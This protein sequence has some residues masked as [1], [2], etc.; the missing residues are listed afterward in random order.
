LHASERAVALCRLKLE[1]VSS[2]T[3]RA[4]TNEPEA[5]PDLSRRTFMQR[6][7]VVAGGVTVLATV[8]IAAG[9]G[10]ALAA[11]PE[12]EPYAPTALTKSE[13]ATLKAI[14]SRLIPADDL[15]PGATESGVDVYIDKSLAGAYAEFLPLYQQNLPGLDKAAAKQ[16]AASFAALGPQAQDALLKQA[17][18][19]K[20]GAGWA[21]FFQVLLE[22]TREGMFGDPMYGGNHNYAGWDLV[23]Y[24]GIKLYWSA[25]EQAIGTKVAPTHTSDATYGGHPAQ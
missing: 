1:E 20:L 19:G 15:G 2:V 17:E 11:S 10:T 21:T 22:H 7:A 14:I 3:E 13:L 24:P 12:A 25:P 5:V 6:S 16:G 8:P 23:Q 18:T 4:S 9:T